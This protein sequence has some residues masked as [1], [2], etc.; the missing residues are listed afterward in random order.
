MWGTRLL[1]GLGYPYKDGKDDAVEDP[2]IAIRYY[3]GSNPEHVFFHSQAAIDKAAA[4][5]K[6][7]RKF[8]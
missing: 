4:A 1:Q 3:P 5:L 8:H 2:K 6:L 7:D